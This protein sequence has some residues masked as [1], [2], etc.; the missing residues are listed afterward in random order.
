L[1]SLTCKRALLQFAQ[2]LLDFLSRVHDE[3]TMARDG[4]VQRLTGHKKKPRRIL[5]GAHF[6]TVAVKGGMRGF[7]EAI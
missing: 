2:C 3:W 7:F 4:L 6:E 1:I 5:F